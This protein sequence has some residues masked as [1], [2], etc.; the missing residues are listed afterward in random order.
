MGKFTKVSSDAFEALQL[1]AGVLL[2][3]FDPAN[4]YVTP[5]D[6][7]IIATTSG[8]INPTCVPTYSDFG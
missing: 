3:T 5:T 8:G 4:P 1:D 6:A 7:Q 2:T